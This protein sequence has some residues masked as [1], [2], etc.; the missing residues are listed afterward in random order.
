MIIWVSELVS[1]MVHPNLLVVAAGFLAIS[2][3]ACY[4]PSDEYLRSKGKI[5][6]PE[7]PTPAAEEAVR[8]SA[9]EASAGAVGTGAGSEGAGEMGAETRQRIS[10][11]DR[12]MGEPEMI[13]LFARHDLGALPELDKALT[14]TPDKLEPLLRGAF[15]GVGNETE[16][17]E[18]IV[19]YLVI[20]YPKMA[21]EIASAAGKLNPEIQTW[22]Q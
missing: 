2:L 6:A 12:E 9:E 21:G 16:K 17:C 19:L 8:R 11:S 5:P 20:R 3:S 13:D 4:R 18:E 7:R 14:R 22:K 15:A 1:G 10:E